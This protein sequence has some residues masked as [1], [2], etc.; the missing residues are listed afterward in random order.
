[1]LSRQGSITLRNNTYPNHVWV[2]SGIDFKNHS[3][4]LG[5]GTNLHK[6]GPLLCF[7]CFELF[8]FFLFNHCL[9]MLGYYIL[10]RWCGSKSNDYFWVHAANAFVHQVGYTWVGEFGTYT[11]NATSTLKSADFV[12]WSKKVPKILTKG[13][14][15]SILK[16][17]HYDWLLWFRIVDWLHVLNKL[18]SDTESL[19]KLLYKRLK[20]IGCVVY[21]L[22]SGFCVHCER[23]ERS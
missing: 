7:S 5:C 20:W 1:M 21:Y 3:M 14:K 2:V 18:Y 6:T 13:R 19:C 23:G 10:A 15:Y 17:W 16:Y 22:F 12:S 9:Q 11:M 4:I 8:L